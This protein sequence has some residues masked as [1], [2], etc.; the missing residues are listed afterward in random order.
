M[1]NRL[2]LLVPMV[3]IMLFTNSCKDPREKTVWDYIDNTKYGVTEAD[4]ERGVEEL[5]EDLIN[6]GYMK[7]HSCRQLDCYH[8]HQN[9]YADIN[10]VNDLVE[11]GE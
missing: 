6:H 2:I 10:R 7:A 4:W 8:N 5:H 11:N 1:I 9:T 3:G